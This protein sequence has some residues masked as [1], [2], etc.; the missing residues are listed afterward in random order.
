[1]KKFCAGGLTATL[2]FGLSLLISGCAGTPPA[3]GTAQANKDCN[4]PMQTGSRLSRRV[5][6]DTDNENAGEKE[7]EIS[8]DQ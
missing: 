4:V 1:M 2:F 5:C 8:D 6:R 3:D 7:T